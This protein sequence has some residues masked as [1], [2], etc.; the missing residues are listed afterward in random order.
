MYDGYDE[1]V[2]FSETQYSLQEALAQGTP[3]HLYPASLVHIHGAV[4]K[5]EMEWRNINFVHPQKWSSSRRGNISHSVLLLCERFICLA[6]TER[7]RL[8][9][10]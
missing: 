2:R 6:E 9:D 7:R 8:L 5:R 4:C 10:K 1:G 3:S